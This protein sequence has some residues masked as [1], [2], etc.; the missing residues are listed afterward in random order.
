MKRIF[1]DVVVESSFAKWQTHKYIPLVDMGWF[2]QSCSF[3]LAIGT[4][5]G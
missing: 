4:A 1:I 2:G 5:I 3:S